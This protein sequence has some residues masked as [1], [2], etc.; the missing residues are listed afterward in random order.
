LLTKIRAVQFG[1]GPIGCAVARLA[2]Q[3]PDIDL[4]GALDIDPNKIGRDLGEVMGLETKLGITVTNDVE[5]L[6][7]SIKPDLVFHQTSS[8]L[9]TV[10]PQLIKLLGLGV[11]IVST[12]EE[13]S[14]PDIRQPDLARE[15]DTVARTNQVTVLGTGINPGFLMDTWP[16]CMSAVCQEIKR[17][18]AVRV[19]D[20]RSRR[21][22]FQKKIGA[23]CT[24]DEFQALV[25]QG[26][27]RHVG[28][29]ESID[30]IATGLGWSLDKVTESI[31]PVIAR[32][33]VKSQYLT[34]A[35][36]QVAGVRQVGRGFK[37][38]EELVTLEFEASLGAPESYD[39]VYLTGTPNLEVVIKGGT[40][41]DIATAAI[42]V[43]AARRV[44]DAPPGL[45]TMKDLPLVTGSAQALEPLSPL[46]P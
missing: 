20:A 41:G 6:L 5:G 1:C 19:Q 30:M 31:E 38:E 26:T 23:G 15:I 44:V 36:G 12:T 28:L 21:L 24:T 9:K 8:S 29:A 45:I 25:A 35:A 42:V 16:L 10:A 34:V 37:D 14:Y 32:E 43:N 22:P 11:N 4:A 3:R 40:H 7:A 33:Q 2:W 13:L 17:V 18:K 27:L 46:S 39:A